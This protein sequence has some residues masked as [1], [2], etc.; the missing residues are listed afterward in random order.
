MR[1]ATE[2]RGLICVCEPLA[3]QLAQAGIAREKIHVVPNGVDS[4]RFRY[5]ER[6]LARRELLSAAQAAGPGVTEMFLC[7]LDSSDKIILFVGNLVDVKAPGILLRAF[8]GLS[9]GAAGN[10]GVHLAVIGSGVMRRTLEAL[11]SKLNLE[12]RIHFLGNVP[13]QLMPLWMNAA[14]CLGLSSRREGMPNVVLEA[15]ASGLPLV[16]TNVG[17]CEEMTSG[18][19]GARV[20]SV[21]DA[22]AM[23]RA[24]T[25]LLGI[26]TDRKELAGRHGDYTWRHQAERIL[27]IIE[28]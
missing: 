20:V 17:A 15:L 5:R 16:C 18:E 6:D 1:A 23:S 3:D 10:T 22:A 8:S 14:D 27:A 24:L 26:E 4:T 12:D 19:P 21:D 13:H 2:C 9:G 11:A 25:E 28:P 7:G